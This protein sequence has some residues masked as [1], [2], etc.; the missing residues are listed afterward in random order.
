[1]CPI[2]IFIPHLPPTLNIYARSHYW[3]RV[4]EFEKVELMMVKALKGKIPLEPLQHAKL[5]LIRLSAKAP[6][7]D[8]LVGGMKIP[9][10]ILVKLGILVDD[11]LSV[12]GPWN[13]NWNKAKKREQGIYIKV[14]G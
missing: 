7:Y 12:T 5:T 13:V 4:K 8:G 3:K 11:N 10:D 9:V 14:E 2:E 1:M 6:D